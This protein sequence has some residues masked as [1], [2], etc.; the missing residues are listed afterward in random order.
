[1]ARE[2][3]GLQIALII[4]VMLT[5]VMS[6]MCVFLLPRSMTRRTAR[7]A[8]VDHAVQANAQRLQTEA[9]MQEAQ[10]AHRFCLVE[11]DPGYHPPI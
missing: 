8:A 5:V 4:F 10:A 1:M 7:R 6:V 3:Q 2:N 11:D 9:E